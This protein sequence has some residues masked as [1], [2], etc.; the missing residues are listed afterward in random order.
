MKTLQL[1]NAYTVL[2]LTDVAPA[3]STLTDQVEPFL[4][5]SP[6]LV[7]D[8][9]GIQFNSMLIGELVNVHRSFEAR[10]KDQEHRIA[11]VH[12]SDVSRSV[13]ERVR[14][15]EMFPIY[16]SVGEALNGAD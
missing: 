11:L 12:L 9:D 2:R 3:Q 8:V 1:K 13:F 7:L 14:L 6:Q 10:W 15:T 4:G 5:Q 16:G